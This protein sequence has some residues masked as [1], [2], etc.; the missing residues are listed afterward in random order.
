MAL[1]VGW[2]PWLGRRDLA[3]SGLIE[4]IAAG[5]EAALAQALA[6]APGNPDGAVVLSRVLLERGR[7]KELGRIL[8]AAL[9]A[10][11]RHA[12][13]WALMGEA[14]RAADNIGLAIEA[15]KFSA[16]ADP[17]MPEAQFGLGSLLSYIGDA[18]GAATCLRRAVELQPNNA[19][20]HSN[21]LMALQYNAA[22]TREALVAE[23]R[24]WAAR[25]APVL[26]PRPPLRDPDPERPLRV[27]LVSGD[28]RFH[29]LA[30]FFLEPLRRRNRN[31]W[32]AILYSTVETPDAFTAA[33]REEAD[34]WR[35]V[36]DVEDGRLGALIRED[37]IDV[38][39]DLN[40]HSKGNRLPVFALRPA[41]VQATWMDYVDTTGLKAMDVLIVDRY[42]A[43]PEEERFYAEPIV[44][45]PDDAICYTPPKDAPE[46]TPPPHRR[47]GRITFGCFNTA[48]K[49]GPAVVAAWGRILQ[50]VPGSRMLLNAPE[51][52]HEVV[53][54][55]YL[56]Q[57]AEAGI[58]PE[59]VE[60]GQ[61]GPH[62]DFM[63]RYAEL[64]IALD[65]FPYSGGLNTCEALWMGVPVI[66][67]PGDRQAGRLATSHLHNAGFA[68]LVAPNLDG[69]VG[70]AVAMAGEPE[71]LK[72]YREELR[73][74][75][76]AS[77]LCD[78]SR[79]IAN[80]EAIL[81]DLW[82]RACRGL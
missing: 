48:Y 22:T 16:A 11:P 67:F 31:A 13:A 3:N 66:A 69:Y 61:G 36:A 81:R 19:R 39:V 40:G 23:H 4:G 28:F 44:R 51:F 34:G 78:A 33:F 8:I 20:A 73:P 14:H 68:E 55:R 60:F 54:T 62:R 80:F 38:M 47:R 26:P 21:Y 37:R 2:R 74:S 72:A 63:A 27:G 9:G 41:P 29:A 76:A 6:A 57:F 65:P 17:A 56:A 77:P 15:W 58:A 53:R 46:V 18:E 82:R 79:F 10:N 75:L 45:L 71:R 70:L 59:R 49:I 24:R 64:D 32:G 42:L 25:H 7:F 52:R 5:D 30:H 35:D 12:P 1:L 50:Q 43:R